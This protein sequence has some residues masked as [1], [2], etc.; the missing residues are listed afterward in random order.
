MSDKR[1]WKYKK[2]CTKRE[3]NTDKNL[4]SKKKK[5]LKQP[6]KELGKE[7]TKPQVSW[8]QEIRKIRAE[9]NKR[10][11]KNR[12]NNQQNWVQFIFEKINWQTLRNTL[13][14]K[15]EDLNK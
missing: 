5:D 1:K 6:F 15:R 12:R 10:I 2:C 14:K 9:I 7:Q 3:V 4:H 13:K 11:K 8:T